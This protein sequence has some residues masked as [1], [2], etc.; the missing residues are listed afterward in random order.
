MGTYSRTSQVPFAP[1]YGVLAL[2]VTT[3]EEYWFFP[4]A[5]SVPAS[6]AI[7]GPRLIAPAKDGNVYAIDRATGTLDWQALVDAGISSPAVH[8]DTVF[9]GGGAFGGN[10]L[11]V[12][13]DVTSGTRRWSFAPN[14][15]VQASITY[16]YGEVLFATNSAHGTVYAVNATTGTLI[17]SFEP[18]PAEY[19]L[20]APVVADG[21]VFAPSDNGHVYAL[22]QSVAAPVAM[23]ASLSPWVYLGVPIVV[24]AVIAIAVAFAFRRRPRRGL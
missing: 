2:N 16:A 20:G 18:S 22:G 23:P 8:G 5:G 15:P 9:V 4:T 17:W 12:A 10:G 19:I 6:P 3:G 11:V 1:P 14:G 21:V 7:A 24:A 13:L